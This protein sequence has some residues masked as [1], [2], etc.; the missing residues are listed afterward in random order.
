MLAYFVPYRRPLTRRA[1]LVGTAALA[2]CARRKSRGF[3]G[4]AFVANAGAR[5]VAA[6]DLNAFVLAKQIGLDGAPGALLSNPVRPGVF[7]LMPESGAVCEIDAA[8]LAVVC[9]TRLGNPAVTMR[10]A[11]DGK[12][13]WV[14]QA[15]AL[16]RV[17]G[18]H[19]RAVQTIKLPGV[20]GDFDVTSDGRGVVSFREERRLALVRLSTG[21]IEHLFDAGCEPSLVRF[22]GDGKQVL[23]GSRADRSLTIFD[24]ASGR[25]TVRLPL[26]VEPVNCCFNS[27]GGQM[28]VTGPGMDAVVIVYPYQTEVGETILA[29]R[30]PDGMAV[31]GTPQYL[32]VANPETG[33]VTVLDIETR[34]LVG[35]MDVGQEPRHILITPDDRYALVLNWRSGNMAVIRIAAF[36]DRRHRT[37]PAPLFTIVPVGAQPVAAAVVGV[38]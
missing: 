2:S 12:S 1:L 15:R 7:V 17:E 27:D 31:S 14:L 20:A 25:T 6:V 23:A 35:A 26:P 9:K 4:F 30:T 13:L 32:F 10:L 16:V 29:G 3:P 37:D 11:A 24:A 21:A 5:T 22:Q 38:G 33:S 18:M 34:K 36:T 19:L 8:K 28:F